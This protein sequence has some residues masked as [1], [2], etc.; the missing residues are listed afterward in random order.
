MSKNELTRSY[1]KLLGIIHQKNSQLEDAWMNV[2]AKS[3]SLYGSYRVCQLVVSLQQNDQ[4]QKG[5][6][7]VN[8]AVKAGAKGER[9]KL[10]FHFKTMHLI[11]AP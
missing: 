1:Q 2:N 3:S 9:D 8:T 7:R 6:G 11:Y 4:G 5:G 10:I